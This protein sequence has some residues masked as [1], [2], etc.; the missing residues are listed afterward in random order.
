MESRYFLKKINSRVKLFVGIVLMLISIFL[1]F[2]I[3]KDYKEEKASVKPFT[4]AN[5]YGEYVYIDVTDFT[6]YFATYTNGD[7]KQYYYFLYDGKYIYIGKISPSNYSKL[8]GRLYGYTSTIPSD[9]V[10]I[11]IE[12]YNLSAKDEVLNSDNVYDYLGIYYLDNYKSP[13]SDLIGL[14][15]FVGIAFIIGIVLIIID[16]INKSKIKKEIKKYDIEKL[17]HEIDSK[18]TISHHKGKLYFTGK[19]IIS[20][21][22][23][24][25]IINYEDVVWIYPHT[26]KYRGTTSASIM[27]MDKSGKNHS[28]GY[29][30]LTQKTNIEFDEM[31]VDLRNKLPHSLYGYTAEN[32]EKAQDVVNQYKLK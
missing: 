31:Y 24:L 27:V 9:L 21:K 20:Y 25:D 2:L 18:D 4:E 22:S 13:A 19:N 15:I 7:T 28:I 30:P 17:S 16:S 1:E 32:M 29:M 10:D 6:D 5:N 8:P 23:K 12:E 14:S 26:E 3:I 11:A